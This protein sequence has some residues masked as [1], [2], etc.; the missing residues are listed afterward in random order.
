KDGTL[1]LTAAGMRATQKASPAH[2]GVMVALY[3][4]PVAAKQIAA[5]KGVTEPVD[6]LHLTLAFLGDSSETALSTNKDKLIAAIEQ[7]ATQKGTALE[8]EIN[9]LGRFFHSEDDDTNAVFVSPD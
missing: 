9:G 2:T 6:Q 4:D 3:P 8:G 1:V 5:Q 7:W